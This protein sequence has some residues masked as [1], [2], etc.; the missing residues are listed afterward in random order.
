MSAHNHDEEIMRKYGQKENDVDPDGKIDSMLEFK[1]KVESLTGAKDDAD[2][3]MS[4]YAAKI[5]EKKTTP[6]D[7]RDVFKEAVGI[8]SKMTD[9]EL[10]DF[11]NKHNNY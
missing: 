9:Q 4:I 7:I 2:N 10:I 11:V 8:L 1:K 5:S 6:T 3:L